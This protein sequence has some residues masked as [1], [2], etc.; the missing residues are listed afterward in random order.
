MANNQNP[1]FEDSLKE[2]RSFIKDG[3]N[4][5]GIEETII[6]IGISI[7]QVEAVLQEF[8]ARLVATQRLLVDKGVLTDTELEESVQKTI[9]E[10]E[11]LIEEASKQFLEGAQ[12]NVV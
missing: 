12:E 1:T 2:I 11:Q 8:L 4:K 5:E 3:M 6:Q 9:Q 10:Q 7:F